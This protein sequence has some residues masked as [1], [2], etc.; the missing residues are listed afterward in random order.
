MIITRLMGGLGNQ[1]FQYAFGKML[2]EKYASE[3]VLDLSLLN[4]RSQPDKIATHRNFELDA[5]SL[6]PFRFATEEEAVFYNG[7]PN[8]SIPQR[9]AYRYRRW[10]GKARILVQQRNSYYLS[11][12]DPGDNT[13]VVGRWQSENYFKNIGSLIRKEFRL[14]T[15]L[16]PAVMK[17]GEEMRACNSLAVHVRRG[18]LVSSPLYSKTIGA[19]PLSYYTAG[20]AQVSKLTGETKVFV[21]SDDPEWCKAN[22]PYELVDQGLALDK[23]LGHFYLMQQ[24]RNQVISNSTFSWWAAWLNDNPGKQVVG[25][26]GWYRDPSL[27]NNIIFPKSWIIL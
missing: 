2:A 11:Q 15:A 6:S 10:S 1:M 7:V 19:L 27:I 16:P 24:C 5:F 20:I 17:L 8:G 18:D 25:P 9:I 26:F 12:L 4:D 14:K 21:F 3:L 22:L 23:G 13:C